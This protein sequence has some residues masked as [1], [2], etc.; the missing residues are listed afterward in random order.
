MGNRSSTSSS[1]SS[2]QGGQSGGGG[3]GSGYPAE[4]RLRGSSASSSLGGRSSR[5]ARGSSS[6]SSGVMSSSAR[7]GGAPDQTTCP[8]C[9][10]VLLIPAN[11]PLFRCP[12][13]VLFRTESL[14]QRRGAAGSVGRRGGEFGIGGAGGGGAVL[15]GTGGSSLSSLL[16]GI[17]AAGGP[18][19]GGVGGGTVGNPPQRAVLCR[20]CRRLSL[21]PASRSADEVAICR[22]GAPA[23]PLNDM[24]MSLLAEGGELLVGRGGFMTEKVPGRGC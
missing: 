18:A 14:L 9:Q 19:G 12:C 8:E 7:G 20:R 6:G 11:A 15:M 5:G 13:G 23:L 16:L 10:R 4:Y 2:G 22:C 21:V 3:S 24:V 17:G 1:S